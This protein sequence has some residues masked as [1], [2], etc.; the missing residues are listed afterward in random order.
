MNKLLWLYFRF[1]FTHLTEDRIN[2]VGPLSVQDIVFDLL[3]KKLL[4]FLPEVWGQQLAIM[5]EL[6]IS[7][8][9]YDLALRQ[10]LN[11]AEAVTFEW[12]IFCGD[13]R[14]AL[15]FN[16][17]E[18]TIQTLWLP[19]LNTEPPIILHVKSGTGVSS[20][21]LRFRESPDWE[22]QFEYGESLLT[23]L[24]DKVASQFSGNLLASWE[25]Q[26][27]IVIFWHLFESVHLLKLQERNEE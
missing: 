4:I 7:K 16:V 18:I 9:L 11:T 23:L 17:E 19:I 8:Y 3:I 1:L 24:D 22:L 12:D 6:F 2:Y 5:T 10:L 25:T 21:E 26:T 14:L 20:L 27:N 15:I 13:E